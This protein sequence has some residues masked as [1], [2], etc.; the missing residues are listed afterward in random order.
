[1]D[2]QI[3]RYV[4]QILGGSLGTGTCL[5]GVGEHYSLD[6]CM[7]SPAQVRSS[8]NPLILGFLW[9]FH[10]VGTINY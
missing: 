6:T 9:K 2:I 7:H 1:M 5:C 10:Y 3:K 8:P 4:G